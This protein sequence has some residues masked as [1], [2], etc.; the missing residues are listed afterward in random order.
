MTTTIRTRTVPAA[1]TGLLLGGLLVVPMASPAAAAAPRAKTAATKVASTPTW[2][3]NVSDSFRRKVKTGL[4]SSKQGGRYATALTRTRVT[5]G[6]GTFGPLRAGATGVATLRSARGYDQQVRVSFRVTAGVRRGYGTFVSP[7]LRRQADGTAYL[8]RVRVGTHGQVRVSIGKFDRRGRYTALTGERAVRL[9]ASTKRT[10]TVEGQVVGQR[11][12]I[13]AVRA[14]AAG[15]AAPKWQLRVVDRKPG[16]LV[17]AGHVGLHVYRAAGAGRTDVVLRGIRGWNRR[18]VPVKT[19][20]PVETTPAPNTPNSPTTPAGPGADSA[21]GASTTIENAGAR[22]LG[23]ARYELPERGV[24]VAGTGNDSSGNGSVG[25]PFATIRRAVSAVRA[26]NGG[27]IVLRG[28]VYNEFVQLFQNN[29]TIEAY[30]GEVVWLDGTIPVQG[31]TRSGNTWTHGGWPYKFDHSASH[32]SGSDSGGFVNPAHPMAA[33][34]D[35][36]LADGKQ[37]EQVAGTPGEGEFSVD[38]ARQTITVGSDPTDKAMRASNL[39]QAFVI[40]AGNVTLRGF[41][42][43]NYATSLP[44]MGTIYLGGDTGNFLLQD[45]VVSGNSTQGISGYSKN[46]RIDHV[47]AYGN[48]MT[49][50]HATKSTNMVISNSD[51]SGNN[52]EHFNSG[53]ASAGIKVGRMNGFTATNNWVHDNVGITGIWTDENVTNFKIVNNVVDVADANGKPGSQYGILTELSDTGIVAGNVIKNAWYGYTAFDTGNVAIYNNTL[54]GNKVWD[55]GASQDDRYLPG[56]GTAAVPPASNCPWVV[57]NLTVVNNDLSRST[58]NFQ[59]YAL[60]KATKRTADSMNISL[61][62]NLFVAGDTKRHA[63]GWG[64]GNIWTPTTFT[65]IRDWEIAKNLPVR[66][67]NVSPGNVPTGKSV[68]VTSVGMPSAVAALLGVATGTKLLGAL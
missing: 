4:G 63:V 21:R 62:G 48:G 25:A 11:T 35:Q 67:G 41:G 45:L 19:T 5:P 7:L 47:D 55:I 64:N 22:P 61:A 18:P 39:A 32:Q 68:L 28:G 15:K 2:K 46:I 1:V 17:R 13:V 66:N 49:G 23:N 24:Y 16:V 60:D 42:V 44:S 59:F 9:T 38:Y 65:T 53:P 12:P 34:A 54:S 10:V 40:G 8:A 57:R 36:V 37:L 31:W 26:T 30:P 14:W 52:A 50:I 58:A 56:R 51:I 3:Q 29:V 33:W 43:R 20:K 6:K 27:T